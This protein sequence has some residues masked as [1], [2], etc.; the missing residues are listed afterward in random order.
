MS[1]A[2]RQDQKLHDARKRSQIKAA[3]VARNEQ[4]ARYNTVQVLVVLF[5]FTGNPRIED[6]AGAV[7]VAFRQLG[8]HVERYSIGMDFTAVQLQERLHNF[9]PRRSSTTLAIVYYIGYS[10]NNGNNL[11][12]S[13]HNRPNDVGHLL[14]TV[15]SIWNVR[16]NWHGSDSDLNDVLRTQGSRFQTVAKIAWNSISQ[17]IMRAACDTIVILDCQHASLAATS[18]RD[19]NQQVDNYRKEFIGANGW[20]EE[21]GTHISPA[22]I[23]ILGSAFPPPTSSISTFDLVRRMN[24]RMLET[25]VENGQNPA[26]CMHYLF[27]RNSLSEVSLPNLNTDSSD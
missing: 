9:F 18:L 22:L 13:S 19:N 6:E 15:G 14:D 1:H 23:G 12:L 26:R 3:R 27:Q 11:D 4:T 8:Y 21:I 17:N 25:E 7:E 5:Q 24:I 20:R 10:V 2:L 16:R